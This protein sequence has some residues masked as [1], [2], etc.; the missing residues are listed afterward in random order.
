MV[1]VDGWTR[2]AHAR[3]SAGGTA[4]S[5]SPAM[6]MTR[7]WRS[8]IAGRSIASRDGTAY[9]AHSTAHRNDAKDASAASASSH[10]I[11]PAAAPWL[12]PTI[13][14]NGPRD[15][16][17]PRKAAKDSSQPLVPAPSPP[18]RVHHVLMGTSSPGPIGSSWGA[19]T[20][21]TR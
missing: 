9:P 1:T 8:D 13:P 16:H 4:S 7:T 15:V 21:N 5:A 20:K 14:W 11:R 2:D 12:K 18:S 17:T 6:S 10:K 3:V 19:S